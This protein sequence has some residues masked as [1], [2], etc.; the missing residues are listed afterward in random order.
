MTSKRFPAVT[1]KEV[2]KV[3][4]PK[5]SDFILHAI[6]AV[7]LGGRFSPFDEFT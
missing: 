7:R 6:V 4:E 2:V 3:L 5:L 1:S